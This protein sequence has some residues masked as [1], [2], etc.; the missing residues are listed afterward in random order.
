MN[1]NEIIEAEI[2]KQVEE[3]TKEI[4]NSYKN[5]LEFYMQDLL[6]NF[7]MPMYMKLRSFNIEFEKCKNEFDDCAK[8]F[9]D[10]CDEIFNIKD[11]NLDRKEEIDYIDKYFGKITKDPKTINLTKTPKCNYPKCENYKDGLLDNL[12]NKCDSRNI[13]KEKTQNALADKIKETVKN[14]NKEENIKEENAK[15]VDTKDT[16][17]LV[18]ETLDS[19]KDLLKQ[20]GISK[21]DFKN[22]KIKIL[23]NKEAYN[24]LSKIYTAFEDLWN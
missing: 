18:E 17:K 2:K 3:R 12:C 20:F 22:A 7:V 21:D 8:T 19:M 11:D 6:D 4:E 5:K 16:E 15:I 9:F 13:T 1:Y 14:N 24:E 10:K 23:N